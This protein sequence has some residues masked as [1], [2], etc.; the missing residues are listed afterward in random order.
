MLVPTRF[1]VHWAGVRFLCSSEA[2]F[3]TG[4]SLVIDG[5]M[6]VQLQEDL[7][8]LPPCNREP[9]HVYFLAGERCL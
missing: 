3:I 5:G 7:G 1:C 9:T 2:K 6:T 4:H 8:A